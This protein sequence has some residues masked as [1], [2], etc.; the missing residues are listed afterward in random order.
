MEEGD[1]PLLHAHGPGRGDKFLLTLG[2]NLA[3]D[4]P[5]QARP[6]Q[7]A[8]DNHDDEDP[9]VLMDIGGLEDGRQA[10]RKG[11]EGDGP[12]DL[13]HTHEQ[14]IHNAAE[15]AGDTAHND[16]DDGG[17]DDGH[18]ADGH[19]HLAAVY[20]AVEHI[21]AHLVGAHDI[22]LQ[23]PAAHKAPVLE[24][25]V[26]EA[27]GD[28]GIRRAFLLQR[29]GHIA[30]VAVVLPPGVYPPLVGEQGK[31]PGAAADGDGVLIVHQLGHGVLHAGH[32]DLA[33]VGDQRQGAAGGGNVHQL[34][35]TQV[36]KQI[37]GH[38]LAVL[39]LDC[40]DIVFGALAVDKIAVLINAVDAVVGE[41]DFL[42]LAHLLAVLDDGGQVGGGQA[43]VTPGVQR[44]VVHEDG[45]HLVA[46]DQ[47]PHGGGVDGIV[48]H[49]LLRLLAGGHNHGAVMAVLAVVHLAPA[50]HVPV[51]RDGHAMVGA[52]GHMD[53]FAVLHRLGDL[54][55]IPGGVAGGVEIVAP[56]GYLPLGVHA[57]GE[58]AAGGDIQR[59][60]LHALGQL[61]QAL[62]GGHVGVQHLAARLG[63]VHRRDGR[64]DEHEQEHPH[65]HDHRAGGQRL[66][67]KP[68]HR[69]LGG[70]VVAVVLHLA[71]GT[72]KHALH[73][74]QGGA[75]L[76]RGTIL[77]THIV[78]PPY[79]FTRTR[80]SARP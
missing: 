39:V 27:A 60:V 35:V 61:H 79:L 80:G 40:D 63:Q 67:E 71:V 49:Q 17:D 55:H 10:Q 12:H 24:G 76:L 31:V 28:H 51:L 20:N 46:A 72:H 19:G 73:P 30:L 75:P 6:A 37:H 44:A 47:L 2:Q 32:D 7:H 8:Q 15:I 65:Q 36:L 54:H 13:A 58:G 56:H 48:P 78:P 11:E 3:A 59:A 18:R 25:I 50:I 21:A 16:A 45:G 33:V 29:V 53:D 34:A 74:A 41:H 52:R 77:F 14:H 69:L 42:Q 70:A 57:D 43:V 9:G 38:V 1:A 64:A 4:Q 22:A 5:G 62:G 68:L 26:L 23:P 66:A